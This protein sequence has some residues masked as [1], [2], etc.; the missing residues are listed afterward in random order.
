[1]E[2]NTRVKV[3]RLLAGEP[4]VAGLMTLSLTLLP[5]LMPGAIALESFPAAGRNALEFSEVGPEVGPEIE[6]TR[7][8]DASYTIIVDLEASAEDIWSV[9]ADYGSFNQFLPNIVSSEILEVEGNRHVVEQVSEQQVLFFQVRSRLRTENLET[10]NQRIDFRLLEGDLNQ[11]EG[12]W[13]IE[14]TEN[15][16]VHRLRQTVTATPP[17]GTP[18]AVFHT[19]F[20]QSLTDNLAA[21]RDEIQRRQLDGE[22]HLTVNP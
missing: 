14:A 11:L 10:Q 8:E 7:N 9:I 21:I 1:M 18:D 3:G 4:L 2:D 6:L 15:P 22:A 19:I 16:Q 13:V 5:S 20:R 12:Y 17:P